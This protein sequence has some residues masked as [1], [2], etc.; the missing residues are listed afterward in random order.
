MIGFSPATPRIG[1]SGAPHPH[2]GVAGGRGER[3]LW[4]AG[5]PHDR[6]RALLGLLR[7]AGVRALAGLHGRVR[8][9]GALRGRAGVPLAALVADADFNCGFN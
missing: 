4:A 9:G 7:R 2:V 5:P 6:R 1:R 3:E 8:A